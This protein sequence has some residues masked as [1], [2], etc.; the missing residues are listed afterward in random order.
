MTVLLEAI[1]ESYSHYDRDHILLERAMELSSQELMEANQ[2]L[3]EELE[4]KRIAEK[5]ILEKDQI[6]KSI[7]EN[8]REAVY[9]SRLKGG[10]VYV[11]QAFVDLFGYGSEEEILKTPSEKFYAYPDIRKELDSKMAAAGSLKSEEV[12]FKRKDGTPF[13]GLLSSIISN[14][15]S[16]NYY[17]DGAIVDITVQKTNEENLI[18]ANEMLKKINSELDKFVYSASHDLR[19]PL[20]SLLGLIRLIELEKEQ[21]NS[22]HLEHMRSS[23]LKLDN[24]IG[25][26][27]D[28]SRNARLEATSEL[29][30]FNE[31]LEESFQHFK[32]VPFAERIKKIVNLDN[33]VPFYTDKIRLQI[34]FNNLISNAINYH[35]P[36]EPHPFIKVE[37]NTTVQN[38]CIKVQDNGVGIDDEQIEKI[39]NMFYRGSSNST[40]SGLGL[41]IV[42]EILDK[43][44]GSIQVSSKRS[45]GTTFTLTIPNFPPVR[46]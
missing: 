38:S 35:N 28:Y 11:N 37:V 20:K 45:N 16:G 42:K 9:R 15:N 3:K 40:G 46:M 39:F 2:K 41:Y 32:Y 8:L 30:D 21:N 10:L 24:F 4:N 26:I 25:D 29:I 19:A 14:D 27:I 1:N 31:L 6:L 43:L 12:L 44:D 22:V 13:W 23:I 34:V 5:T 17:Y 18:S 36:I 33:Q 7:N